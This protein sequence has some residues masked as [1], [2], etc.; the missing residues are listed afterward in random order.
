[1]ISK[2]QRAEANERADEALRK[3]F[4]EENELIWGL[5]NR[6]FLHLRCNGMTNDEIVEWFLGTIYDLGFTCSKDK[7]DKGTN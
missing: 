5:K 6:A 2:E 3:S 1:M 7:E 4:D